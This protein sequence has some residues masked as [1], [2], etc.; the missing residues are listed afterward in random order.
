MY[1][2]VLVMKRA[3]FKRMIDRLEKGLN[4]ISD[5]ETKVNSLQK[6]IKEDEPRLEKLDKELSVKKVDLDATLLETNIKVAEVTEKTKIQDAEVK[7]L[8][9]MKKSIEFDKQDCEKSKKEA[10][11]LADK[12]KDAEIKEVAGY[13]TPSDAIMSLLK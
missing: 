8:N 1:K 3:D 10:L 4:T 11:E 6:Q 7:T 5:A 2:Q 9:E 12:F 13:G